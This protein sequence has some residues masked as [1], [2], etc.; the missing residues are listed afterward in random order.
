VTDR[1][2]DG[3]YR[4]VGEPLG[5][6][7]AAVVFR[8]VDEK[9]EAPRAIK[10]LKPVGDPAI[11]AALV[12]RLAAE[13]RAM[14]RIDHPNVLKV[15]ALGEGAEPYVV[16]ALAE[17]SVRDRVD[18]GP[19]PPDAVA[20]V[21]VQVCAA[22]AA[23]HGGGVVHRDVKP[24]NMLI[25]AHGAIQLADFGIALLADDPGGR[26]T[27]AGAA[28]G[29]LAFVAPEQ[30]ID[31]RTVGPSADVY[32]TGASLY[33]LLTGKNP[34]DLFSAGEDSPR[35]EPVPPALR[36]LILQATH[37][38]PRARTA[39][40]NALG[41]ALLA[42]LPD[43]PAT[44][45]LVPPPAVWAR[46]VRDVLRAPAA[47]R[48]NRRVVAGAVI[49]MAV[50]VVALAIAGSLRH[51]LRAVRPPVP[52]HS[53]PMPPAVPVPAPPPPPVA[54][55]AAPAT[56]KWGTGRGTVCGWPATVEIRG[57]DGALSADLEVRAADG[58]ERSALRGA[59]AA[60]RLRLEGKG[61][62]T[63]EGALAGTRWS[64]LTGGSRRCPFVFTLTRG[65]D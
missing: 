24:H 30:R 29:S 45:V 14:G 2:L 41:S 19:L 39:S 10:L 17:G 40:P 65:A 53:A 18:S 6:G 43:L 20:R 33:A 63:Y 4:L 25:D 31:A 51:P 5:A 44:D 42:V 16:M 37:G 49:A 59:L 56:G 27:R 64:G 15:Y 28:M 7:G 36:P 61:G 62:A 57:R 12:R 46:A 52:A 55:R 32:A 11:A 21:G 26:L 9:L 48:N 47:P 3:R 23:A 22:L 60:S 34:V 35:W 13:A 38:D 8:A 50:L 58:V 54:P 1:L